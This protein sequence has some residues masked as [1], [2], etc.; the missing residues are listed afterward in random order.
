MI[1][2]LKAQ[3]FRNIRKPWFIL[4]LALT[5]LLTVWIAVSP[6]RDQF[7]YQGFMNRYGD[8]SPATVSRFVLGESRPDLSISDIFDEYMLAHKDEH[9]RQAY[10]ST[11]MGLAILG[12]VL[13]AFFVGR[14]L[15]KRKI[16]AVLIPGQSRAEVFVWIVVRYFL[17]AFIIIT[18]VLG[19]IRIQWSVEPRMFDHSYM[20]NTQL[21]FVLYCLAVFSGMMFVT[22]L[23]KRPIPSAI[24]S[25]AF[26]G[27]AVLSGKLIP[28]VSPVSE[29]FMEAYWYQETGPEFWMPHVIASLIIIAVFIAASWLVFRRREI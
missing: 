16:R 15:G 18:A 11:A 28:S 25:L 24:A 12:C 5:F 6:Y 4:V 9:L 8:M 26:V 14:E 10:L 1:R 2:L 7:S 20:V 27:L 13:P 17:V 22:F 19:M 29:L 3:I 23:V 21:R